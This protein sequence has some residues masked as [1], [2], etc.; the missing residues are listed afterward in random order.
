MA[1]NGMNSLDLARLCKKNEVA[2]NKVQECLNSAYS[3]KVSLFVGT[4][5]ET[6]G[7]DIKGDIEAFAEGKFPEG[8]TEEIESMW[9]D[10]T[11]DTCQRAHRLY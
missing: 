1:F 3:R 2:C 4:V 10:E 9:W 8:L 7:K 6:I 5:R 11:E